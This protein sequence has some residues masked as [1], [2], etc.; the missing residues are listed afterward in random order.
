MQARG[1]VIKSYREK[2]R[3]KRVKKSATERSR[4]GSRKNLSL[5]SRGGIKTIIRKY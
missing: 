4:R 5:K 2:A 3:K 1:R